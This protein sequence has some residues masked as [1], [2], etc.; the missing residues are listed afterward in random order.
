MSPAGPAPTIPTWVRL[1]PPG[2]RTAPPVPARRRRTSS[3]ARSGRPDGA[4]R[5]GGVTTS[6]A[7][8]IPS[9]CPIAIAPPFTFTRSSSMPSSR[10]TASDCE[11]NA[12][13]SS[14]RSTSPTLDAGPLE[15]LADGGH[16][17]DPHDRRVDAR[18]RRADERPERLD[19]ER[20]RAFLARDDER[21]GAVVDPARVPGRDRAARPG[22]PASATQASRAVVSGRGCS[23]CSSSPA[24]TSSSANRP[25]AS[26]RRPALLRAR[27]RTR[28]DP[29]GSRPSARRRSRPSRPSTRSSTAPRS[30][31][32]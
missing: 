15:Q 4:A 14:T 2:A 10:T 11:A 6:R 16:R 3:R 9:G 32:S 30:A 22:T 23:S 5:A 21:R 24:A 12:S 8:L 28:P 31:G 27:A 17:P 29:R 20:P 1:T 26:R 13:F 25:A 18:G 7:P 19:P